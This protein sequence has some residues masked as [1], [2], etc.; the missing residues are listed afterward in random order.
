MDNHLSGKPGKVRDFEEGQHQRV[1]KIS[2]KTRTCLYYILWARPASHP[3]LQT[4]TIQCTNLR[5]TAPLVLTRIFL[6]AGELNPGC[7]GNFQFWCAP[8]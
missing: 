3:A 2:A 6:H 8:C 4:A 5:A 1:K 7:A